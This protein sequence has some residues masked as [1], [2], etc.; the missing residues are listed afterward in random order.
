M[1]SNEQ[2]SAKKSTSMVAG[3]IWPTGRTG[4][5]TFEAKAGRIISFHSQSF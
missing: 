3:R 5:S 2:Q 1:E 4:V